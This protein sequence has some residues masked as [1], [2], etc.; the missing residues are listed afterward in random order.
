MSRSPCRRQ[1]GASLVEAM[2]VLAIIG[3]LLG[4][5]LPGWADARDRR[6]LEAASA[7]LATDLRL[8]RSLAVAQGSPV[9]LSVPAA[10]ACYVVHTGPARAC[11]CDAT[12]AATCRDDAQALRVA[13]LPGSGRIALS[14]S[15]ASMLFD[16]DR[17]T[18][19]PTG[20]LRLRLADGRAVHHVVNIMGR[21]R[22]CSPAGRVAGHPPC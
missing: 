21:I 10:Q 5:V 8:T 20:T 1:C 17:G 19:T 2:I 9:R 15:S 7:Q 3:L 6:S 13:T 14:S 18:V 22:S 11:S 4:S 12:G 16:A